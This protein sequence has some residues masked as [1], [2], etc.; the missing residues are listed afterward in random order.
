[1]R[2]RPLSQGG[3][4]ALAIFPDESGAALSHDK[5]NREPTGPTSTYGPRHGVEV[6]MGGARDDDEHMTASAVAADR[7]GPQA[8]GNDP[9]QSGRTGS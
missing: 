8:G 2:T 4:M 9:E 7:G 5:N 1:M 3:E 6:P